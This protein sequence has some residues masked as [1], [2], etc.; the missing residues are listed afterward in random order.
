[1]A[2]VI[3]GR[4]YVAI[5][6]FA[7]MFNG[8]PLTVNRGDTIREGHPLLD[9]KKHLFAVQKVKFEHLPQAIKAVKK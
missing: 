8:H 4:I 1:V 3:A 7:C 6:S 9:G 2:A 5:D